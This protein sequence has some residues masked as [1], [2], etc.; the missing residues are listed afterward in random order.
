MLLGKSFCTLE[1]LERSQGTPEE[2]GQYFE[3]HC[4]KL[5][6]PV[7]PAFSPSLGTNVFTVWTS[8]VPICCWVA[9]GLECGQPLSLVLP[10]SSWKAAALVQRVAHIVHAAEGTWGVRCILEGS[11]RELACSAL[12]RSYDPNESPAFI[13]KEK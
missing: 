8:C 11:S 5:G 10:L 7:L 12:C 2:P 9:R 13:F 3:N 4:S 1:P 6:R